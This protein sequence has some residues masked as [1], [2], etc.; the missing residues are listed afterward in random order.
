MKVFL[1]TEFTGLHQNTSLLSIGIIDEDGRTFYAE[2]SDYDFTQMDEWLLENIMSHM[3]FEPAKPGEEEYY[4]AERFDD[5]PI[6]QDLYKS[7]SLKMR[8]TIK[9]V[10]QELEKWLNQYDKVEIWSDCL[11]YDW[12][13]F[14]QMF[15]GAMNIPSNVYYIPFDIC[16]LFI[17]EGIDPDISREFYIRERLDNIDMP[18]FMKHNALWDAKVI[19]ECFFKLT[20]KKKKH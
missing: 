1:D 9:E 7:Y 14:C 2:I 13:L 11:A 18:L 10:A 5:N 20:D 16:T 6:G 3:I 8:G 17:M 12:M 15:G 4:S 19:R